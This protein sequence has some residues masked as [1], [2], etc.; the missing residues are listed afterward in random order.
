MLFDTSIIGSF[1]AAAV[2]VVFLYLQRC[3]SSNPDR[4]GDVDDGA[5]V[6]VAKH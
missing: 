3:V 5:N 2:V 6:P 1:E 4:E